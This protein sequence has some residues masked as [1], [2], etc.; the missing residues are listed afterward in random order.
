MLDDV[1]DGAALSPDGS[2]PYVLPPGT[3]VSAH[4]FLTLFRSQ[5]GVVL[6]ND[7]DWVRLLRPDGLVVEATTYTT[8]DD[9]KAYS[10]TLDGGDQWTSDYPPS[11]GHTNLLPRHAHGHGYRWPHAQSDR[12]RHRDG[13]RSRRRQRSRRRRVRRAAR[14]ILASST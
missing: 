7:G 4:G 5:S 2:Q 1:D 3:I 14:P 10:K 8:S 9:D 13:R 11:P 12:D 6:N